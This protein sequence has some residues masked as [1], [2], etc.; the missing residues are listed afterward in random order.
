MSK[1]CH[2]CVTKPAS[3]MAKGHQEEEQQ[4]LAMDTSIIILR[5]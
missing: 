2:V 5:K 1:V 4:P 3:R